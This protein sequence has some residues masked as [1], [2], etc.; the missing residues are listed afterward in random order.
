[1]ARKSATE[2]EVMSSNR[3]LGLQ[4]RRHPRVQVTGTTRLV[5]DTPQGMVTLRGNV[6]DLSVSGCAIRVHAPLEKDHEARLEIAVDGEPVWLPGRIM[7]TRTRDQAWLVGV[8]FEKLVPH[9][10]SLLIRLVAERQRN[11][12]RY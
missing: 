4:R 7:W 10:Q 11:Q 12:D 2:D 5:A 9:K 3:A 8:Q 6:V 1:M